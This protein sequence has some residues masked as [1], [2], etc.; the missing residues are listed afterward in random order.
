MIFLKKLII[1]NRLLSYTPFWCW[2]RLIINDHLF[3]HND[4]YW[5]FWNS[6]NDGYFHMEDD[7]YV[8]SVIDVTKLKPHKILLSPEAYDKLMELMDRPPEP[9]QALSNLFKRKLPWQ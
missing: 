2:F 6:I 5:D 3:D 4:R 9:S 7:Y 1:S 8:K